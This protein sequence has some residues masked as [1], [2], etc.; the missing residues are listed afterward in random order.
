M[1]NPIQEALPFHTQEQPQGVQVAWK[2]TINIL[3]PCVDKNGQPVSNLA[4][5]QDYVSETLRGQF[6][7]WGYVKADAST[8]QPDGNLK[9]I[10]V[11]QPYIEG[12]FQ[13]KEPTTM[14]KKP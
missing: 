3:V 4:E 2:A 9:P 7:D 1:K 10:V 13:N 6:L 8:K 11:L 5:A 12:T 14:E